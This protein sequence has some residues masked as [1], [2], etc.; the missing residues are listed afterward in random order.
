MALPVPDVLSD[1]DRPIGRAV[2]RLRWFKASFVQQVEVISQ[3]T[4]VRY[5][6]R[7]D[8]LV[9]A[10]VTWV[11]A[12]EAQKPTTPKARRAYVGFAAGLMLRQLIRDNPL[13]IVSM[14]ANVDPS[15]AAYY[16]PEGYVYVAY[17]LNVRAAVLAQDFDETTELTP[18]LTDIRT[19]WSFKENVAEDPSLAIAFLDLF[20]GGDPDWLSPS[21]FN[22]KRRPFERREVAGDRSRSIGARSDDPARDSDSD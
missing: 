20:S 11:R 22:E 8:R 6:I 1:I 19:W 4:G 9:Q 21:L 16:W 15:N 18:K 12:F 5:R 17:C 14:P 3:A 2:R 10:F 7:E 13:E